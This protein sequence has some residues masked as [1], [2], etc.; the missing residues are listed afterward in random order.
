MV[1]VDEQLLGGLI[2]NPIQYIKH[3]EIGIRLSADDSDTSHCKYNV[4]MYI[5]MVLV[6][7]LHLKIDEQHKD[8]GDL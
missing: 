2:K 3:P 7:L 5:C 8:E 1:V 4:E 6:Y